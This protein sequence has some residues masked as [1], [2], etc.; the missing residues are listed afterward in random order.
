MISINITTYNAIKQRNVVP[1]QQCGP[2][3]E[4]SAV[5]VLIHMIRVQT[6]LQLKLKMNA[7]DQHLD[8]E[9]N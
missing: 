2:Y 9:K 8:L 6:A 4:I 3:V 1:I 5:P 7:S